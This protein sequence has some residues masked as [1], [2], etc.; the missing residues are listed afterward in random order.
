MPIMTFAAEH[1]ITL[2]SNPINVIEEPL[3]P[4]L[5][6]YIEQYSSH[7]EDLNITETEEVEGTMREK[8]KKCECEAEMD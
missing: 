5:Y 3:F 8:S 4:N 6:N 7:T 2:L 1:L